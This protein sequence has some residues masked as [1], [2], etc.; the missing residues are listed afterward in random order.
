MKFFY[1]SKNGFTLIEVLVVVALFFILGIASLVLGFGQYRRWVCYDQAAR[2]VLFLQRARAQAM[3]TVGN[4][5][6]G[7]YVTQNSFISFVGA[8]WDARQQMF[9]AVQPFACPL[10]TNEMQEIVFKPLSGSV[11]Q[12]KY[13]HISNQTIEITTEGVINVQ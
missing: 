3:H 2:L 12:E 6:H 4:S 8:S 13:I 9:D 11:A 7:I 1:A 5:A 10:A